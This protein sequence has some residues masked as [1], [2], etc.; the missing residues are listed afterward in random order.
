M[1]A[2]GIENALINTWTTNI[3]IVGN[4]IVKGNGNAEQA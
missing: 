1:N 4:E 3:V 2:F